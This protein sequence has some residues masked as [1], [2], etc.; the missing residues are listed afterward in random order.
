[1]SMIQ[2]MSEEIQFLTGEPPEE[3]SEQPHQPLKLVETMP[4]P[5][6]EPQAPLPPLPLTAEHGEEILRL[7][8]AL[9]TQAAREIVSQ[10]EPLRQRL[11]KA[12]DHAMVTRKAMEDLAVLVER[13]RAG[14]E[15]SRAAAAQMPAAAKDLRREGEKFLRQSVT[16]MSEAVASERAAIRRDL[17]QIPTAR[18]YFVMCLL[19]VL[20]S[21]AISGGLF[22]L[23]WQRSRPDPMTL[24]AGETFRGMWERA[25]AKER[26]QIEE[27][28]TRPLPRPQG[29]R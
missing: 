19:S 10:T 8:R 25:S 12:T 2:N 7:L 4:A 5:Q 18:Q 26:R 20:L 22:G 16:Q 15:E 21:S 9:P 24:Q 13:L 14:T 23:A 11:G 1:M 29:Q 27:I 3:T 28:I 17:S 6:Q